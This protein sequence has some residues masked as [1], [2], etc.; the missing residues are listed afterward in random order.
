[1]GK[2]TLASIPGAAAGGGL[3]LALACDLRIASADAVF[4]TAFGAVGL[5]SDYGAGWFLTRVVG[6]ARARELL[7]LP[8]RFG[9]A[10]AERIG[11]V[12]RV[13]PAERLEEE[14]ASLARRLAHGPRVALRGMKEDLNRA[15]QVTLE[16]YMDTEVMLHLQSGTTADHREAAQAFV[17]KRPPRFTGR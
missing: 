17:E 11:L 1:M 13:V 15:L 7:F 12:N 3:S 16:D 10:D 6:P 9:A 5:A 8:D 4:T 2:P 14:T